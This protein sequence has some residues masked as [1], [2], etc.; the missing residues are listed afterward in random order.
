VSLPLPISFTFRY[1]SPIVCFASSSFP[2]SLSSAYPQPILLFVVLFF[3]LFCSLFFILRR[4]FREFRFAVRFSSWLAARRPPPRSIISFPRF[5]GGRLSPPSCYSFASVS[6]TDRREDEP[7]TSGTA[8]ARGDCPCWRASVHAAAVPPRLPRGSS[9]FS[10]AVFRRST[11]L[12]LDDEHLLC[13][14]EVS[15]RSSWIFVRIIPCEIARSVR[16]LNSA[17]DPRD[18]C[19]H[20]GAIL[21]T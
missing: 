19:S 16:T 3:P 15:A 6:A 2:L 14:A 13:S 1:R 21:R 17:S 18:Q 12:C 7:R 9:P 10:H 20:S 8:C 11:S 5:T 4:V